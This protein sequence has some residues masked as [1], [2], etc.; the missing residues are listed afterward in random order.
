MP[1]NAVLGQ[2]NEGYISSYVTQNIGCGNTDYPWL[3]KAAIGQRI[4]VTLIDFTRGQV[5][6]PAAEGNLCIV[7]ATIKEGINSAITHTV[8]GRAGQKTVPVF[9]SVS[10]IVEIRII[11]KSKQVNNQDVQFLLKYK[12]MCTA[13]CIF[14][15]S[16]CRTY[17]FLIKDPCRSEI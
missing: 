4:N 12:G 6:T 1:N 3:L 7:Y 10:N 14:F 17:T 8:C 16:H 9:M 2:D 15:N 13:F 5:A 11:S